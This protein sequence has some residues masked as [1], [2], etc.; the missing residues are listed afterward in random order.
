MVLF[1]SSFGFAGSNPINPG[2]GLLKITKVS[3][4]SERRDN[5]AKT[6]T[7]TDGDD[8]DTNTRYPEVQ[9]SDLIRGR[10]QIS[11]PKVRFSYPL[12]L[13]TSRSFYNL[14]M[15]REIG[16]VYILNYGGGLVQGDRI[17]ID[18]E[19]DEGCDLL[20]LS[21]GSTK[22]SINRLSRI[23]PEN[24]D[25]SKNLDSMTIRS[26]AEIGQSSRLI[27]SKRLRDEEDSGESCVQ[28][29]SATIEKNSC[30]LMLPSYVT[31][32]RDSSFL[33]SQTFRLKDQTSGLVYLDWFTS[34]RFHYRKEKVDESEADEMDKLVESWS[35]DRFR[36]FVEVYL[37]E[38]RLLRD[39]IDLNN[40]HDRVNHGLVQVYGNL[41]LIVPENHRALNRTFDYLEKL[42]R[43]NSNETFKNNHQ[44]RN[45]S[46]P[47]QTLWSFD[48]IELKDKQFENLRGLDG[49]NL[50]K[51]PRC[52]M[53]RIC[54]ESTILIQQWFRKNLIGLEEIIGVEFYRNCFG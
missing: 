42:Y 3:G 40:R 45:R 51:L 53:V 50:K 54:S 33:Q 15:D 39:N 31:C 35:F 4:R 29:V 38:R 19:V 14:S 25:G 16:L 36:S 37:S 8:D 6:T 10:H 22:E 9:K 46:S 5:E 26:K 47:D 34:G 52:A 24:G 21:Q 18:L 32:F 20:C 17:T 49:I 30:L 44:N 41:I 43:S 7:T 1:S 13:I 2:Q 48:R 27:P 28:K 12:K 23:D 11:F